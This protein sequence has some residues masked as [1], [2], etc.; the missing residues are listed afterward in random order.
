MSYFSQWRN[1]CSDETLIRSSS[2]AHIWALNDDSQKEIELGESEGRLRRGGK[3]SCSW[4]DRRTRETRE[5]AHDKT[6]IF[7][8]LGNFRR[9]FL[10]V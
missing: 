7:H 6:C 5:D 1:G 2:A 9:N 10:G 8:K 4:R 3:V